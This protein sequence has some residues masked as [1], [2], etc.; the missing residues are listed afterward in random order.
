MFYIIIRKIA[1]SIANAMAT[2]ATAMGLLGL[3]AGVPT[4]GEQAMTTRRKMLTGALA[5]ILPV[6]AVAAPAAVDPIDAAIE[7]H[8]VAF[9]DGRRGRSRSRSNW[10]CCLANHRQA[11]PPIPFKPRCT[12]VLPC[13]AG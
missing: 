5:A 11:L 2:I 10:L 8:R 4:L 13:D 9:A 7:A 6:A 3:G 1:K 12:Y